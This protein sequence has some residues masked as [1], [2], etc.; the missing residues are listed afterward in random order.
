MMIEVFT[1]ERD[2]LGRAKDE[3]VRLHRERNMIIKSWKCPCCQEWVDAA[4]SQH[5]H[6]VVRHRPA[7]V[8]SRGAAESVKRVIVNKADAMEFS[9]QP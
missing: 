7:E 4:V 5:V 2:R 1:V 9:F 3:L 8:A 6:L